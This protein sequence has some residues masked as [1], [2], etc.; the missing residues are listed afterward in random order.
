[1]IKGNVQKVKG[2]AG[3]LLNYAKER[4]PEYQLC[5]PNQPA[6]EVYDLMSAR[7]SETGVSLKANL[8]GNL[9]RECGLTLR[10]STGFSSIS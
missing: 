4:E 9:A 3:D 2:V 6:R 5:D 7:A 1:M 10:G 8:A